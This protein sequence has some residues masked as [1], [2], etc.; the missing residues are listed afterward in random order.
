MFREAAMTDKP[1]QTVITDLGMPDVDGHQV[2][3][4][5][6]AESPNTPIVMITGGGP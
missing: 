2:V 6:K 3:R 1:F 4:T 5:I